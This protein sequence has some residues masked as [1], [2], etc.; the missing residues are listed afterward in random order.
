LH[1]NFV[2]GIISIKLVLASLIVGLFFYYCIVK[3]FAVIVAGGIGS[4]MDNAVPKQFLPL[5]GKPLMYYAVQNF[6]DAF[7]NVQIIVVMH[8][9]YFS[10]FNE[11]RKHITKPC[12]I[13]LVAGG[14]TRFYSVQNGINAIENANA[15]DI[16]LVHDA[17][18]PFAKPS[19]LQNI[20]IEAKKHGAAIPIMPVF[21]SLR[22][23]EQGQ[24]VPV[25]RGVIFR[26]QTPQAAQ[27]ALMNNAFKQE[28][29]EAF[30]DEATVLEAAGHKIFTVQGIE[31]N[32]KI[33][34]PQDLQYAEWLMQKG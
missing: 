18:R 9:D 12:D 27:Y 19:L 11:V 17:A 8:P 29:S 3:V 24:S 16:V 7:E 20:S 5:A 10:N 31:E 13:K 32:I 30:T 2:I 1:V 34:T 26:V 14:A 6:L 28:F 25:D 4:R 23:V 33:T 15:E 21:E 22:R